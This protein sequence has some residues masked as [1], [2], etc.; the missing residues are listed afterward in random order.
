MR[1]SKKAILLSAI[2]ILALGGGAALVSAPSSPFRVTDKAF[3]A[4]ERTVNFVRPGLQFTILGAEIAA[5]G[6][7]RARVKVTDPRGLGL[8][9]EG[10][11]TPGNVNMS[12]VLARIPQDQPWYTS[13]TVRTQTS[14]ITGRAAVQAAA[15]T[16]GRFEKVADGEYIYTF[17]TRLPAGYDRTATHSI[18]VYGNRNLSEFNLGTNYDDAVYSWVPAGGPVTKTRDVIR[19]AT[20]NKCHVDMGFHGGS[21]KSMEGCVMCHQPQTVDPDTGNTVD[22]TVMT[23]KIHMGA[24]LPSVRGG[25]DYCI[26]GNAQSVHCYGQVNFVAGPNRCSVCHDTSAA[27]NMRPAQADAHL[28]NP[29]R[30]ACGSCHDN[31]NFATGQGHVDLP[32]PNDN[33][34]STCHVPEGEFDFDASIIGAHVTPTEASELPGVRFEIV[35]V[36]DGVAGRRPR[37]TFSIKDKDG[38]IIPANRMTSLSLVLAGP[39]T[40]YSTWIQESALQ[41]QDVGGGRFAY[42]FTATI[43]SSARGSYTIGME[44]YRNFTLME[45]TT[46]QMTVRDAG[47]NVQRTFSVDGR[48][49]VMRRQ[50]VALDKCN[51]CH[52]SLSLHGGNRNSIEECVLCHNP[53]VTDARRRPADRAPNESVNFGTMIHRIH[54]GS[55]QE[56]EYSIF[57]F[58]NIEHNYNKA[59]YPGILSNCSSCHINNSHR[60]PLPGNLL[61]VTDPR[62][63]ATS[64]GPEAAACMTCHASRAAAAHGVANTNAVGES[65]ATCHSVT[66][67]FSVDRVHA[68]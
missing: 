48:P 12:F 34:C 47:R 6:T 15:D 63:F 14:P 53:T 50:V 41:A 28:K 17:G 44:G 56:R 5:D 33:R 61:P 65:C 59:G 35:S 55:L 19:T 64:P 3:Y 24:G 1:Q 8:D 22:M 2:V 21:R 27:G 26:I 52:A 23:H 11:T 40:D 9:R 16:G 10:I 18:L 49:V 32:Q 29:S 36:D 67:E 39:T 38:N 37:V 51:A 68:R 62:H 58:S 25:K 45:G 54:S 42:T 60:L 46:R 30:A 13:Y 20:C 31:V 43:P 57:G 4:D 7:V 66:S